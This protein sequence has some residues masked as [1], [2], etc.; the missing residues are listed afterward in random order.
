MSLLAIK[1]NYLSNHENKL[2]CCYHL[3]AEKKYFYIPVEFCIYYKYII[4]NFDC[5]NNKR[6]Y[7][8][9]ETLKN[10]IKFL[11][12][13]KNLNNIEQSIIDFNH[14]INFTIVLGII[15]PDNNFMITKLCCDFINNNFTIEQE[16]KNSDDN[17]KKVYDFMIDK[18]KNIILD[19]LNNIHNYLKLGKNK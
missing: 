18:N 12:L 10:N 4:F 11:T 9:M 14:N 2:L 1:S 19:L 13:Q 15:V 5:I 3:I 7:E 16:L 17:E 6:N 8:T